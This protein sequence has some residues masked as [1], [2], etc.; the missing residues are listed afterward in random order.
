MR[1]RGTNV[2]IVVPFILCDLLI[3]VVIQMTSSRGRRSGQAAGWRRRG[4]SGLRRWCRRCTW[5]WRRKPAGPLILRG[6]RRRIVIIVEFGRCWHAGRC[7]KRW[8]RSAHWW[9]RWGRACSRGLFASRCLHRLIC[10]RQLIIRVGT[11]TRRRIGDR[12]G[13]RRASYAAL[14]DRYLHV[15]RLERT[16]RWQ[17]RRRRPSTRNRWSSAGGSQRNWTHVSVENEVSVI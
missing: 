10:A 8:R 15:G 14:V 1:Y 3:I 11:F 7:R 2:C 9:Q 5:N 16:I 13:R 4:R 12:N 6:Q 17:R